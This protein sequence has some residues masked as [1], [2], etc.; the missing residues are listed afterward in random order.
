MSATDRVTPPR[1]T[2]PEA[3]ARARAGGGKA[4]LRSLRCRSHTTS[5]GA[6]LRLATA[7]GWPRSLAWERE[8]S[9]RARSRTPTRSPIPI[10]ASPATGPAWVSQRPW[11]KARFGPRRSQPRRLTAAGTMRAAAGSRAPSPSTASA[12]SPTRASHCRRDGCRKRTERWGAGPTAPSASS[13]RRRS[14]RG[15]R[16]PVA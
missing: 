13:E 3:R 9:R 1:W 7:A 4:Q 8:S 12:G 5:P 11:A 6:G 2:L 10:S 14:S 15:S 16:R